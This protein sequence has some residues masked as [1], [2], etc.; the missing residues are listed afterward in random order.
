MTRRGEDRAQG[1]A[2]PTV[3]NS[4]AHPS[5]SS[6]DHQE[7]GDRTVS[8][9]PLTREGGPAGTDTPD[10]GRPKPEDRYKP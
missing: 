6:P 8:H 5:Q 9:R 2:K 1:F 7:Q 10:P 4:P 3:A